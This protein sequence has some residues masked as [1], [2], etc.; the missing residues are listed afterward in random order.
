M[1]KTYRRFAYRKID[2]I[3]GGVVNNLGI[4]D[5]DL[6]KSLTKELTKTTLTE[7]GYRRH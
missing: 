2:G 3:I 7:P 1:G 4:K 5:H 6:A